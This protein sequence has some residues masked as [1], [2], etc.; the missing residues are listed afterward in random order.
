MM[1]RT[2]AALS[3]AM[4]L[5]LGLGFRLPPA[6]G[7]RQAPLTRL[8][9]AELAGPAAAAVAPEPREP[10]GDKGS[11][12]GGVGVLLLNLGGPERTEDVEPF[13]YN[14][15]AD[16]DIIRLPNSIGWLQKP[17]ATF[18]SKRRAPKSR[19]AY[20]SI[21]GGSPLGDWTRAQARAL[22]DS[23]AAAAGSAPPEVRALLEASP[24][25]AYIAMRYWYPFT[26]EALEKIAADGIQQ[27]VVLP[28]Y[29]QFS[30]S[31]SGSSLRVL[32]Q[33]FYSDP[34][35]WG[36]QRLQHTVVPFWYQR[37]GYVRSMQRIVMGE[38]E[39]YSPEER[40]EGVHVLFSAHGV[41]KSYV[42]AGDP[43]E[44]QIE[45]CVELIS[46]GL[47]E[48]V[49]SHLSFQSRV[50]P[51]EWLRP[52]TD[53]KLRELGT[54]GVKN[55]VAVPISFVSEHIETLE[56]MDMEY[57]EVAEEAGINGWR[58]APALNTDQEFVDDMASAVIEALCSPA[59]SIAEACAANNVELEEKPLYQRYGMQNMPGVYDSGDD[60]SGRSGGGHGAPAVAVGHQEEVTHHNGEGG[61][62]H[63]L[64]SYVPPAAW[65]QNPGRNADIYT[66]K[67]QNLSI[68]PDGRNED[69]GP[70]FARIWQPRILGARLSE[71][72]VLGAFFVEMCQVKGGNFLSLF[73]L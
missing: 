63:M 13:L 20:D 62:G 23:I 36:P 31:T 34:D 41:P 56:E 18:V 15:F 28:L 52:Y 66:R 53:D 67:T 9:V 6:Q 1:R 8:Q 54:G 72:G 35:T 21:G 33:R 11:K 60:R 7:L 12:Q 50:G 45:R 17:L 51:I 59:V 3:L 40:A 65:A 4:G 2:L 61:S 5:G 43:Y 42:E 58:R 26:E 30:V 22:E 10:R 39:K 70:A 32:Q 47:P 16:P 27:L 38:V 44:A 25:R 24:A 68:G 71:A 73:G 64:S 46:A 49:T 48:D 29:P 55:L 69:E 14:L 57:R 19:A 37:P